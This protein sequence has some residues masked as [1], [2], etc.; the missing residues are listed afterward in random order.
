MSKNVEKTDKNAYKTGKK[1]KIKRVTGNKHSQIS[2][3][4]QKCQKTW[5]T[6]S[7]TSKNFPKRQKT[8][9]KF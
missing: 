8:G 2:K 9:K 5:K 4:G 7:K 3:N 1:I 6:P